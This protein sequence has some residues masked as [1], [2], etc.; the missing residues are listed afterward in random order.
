LANTIVSL[1]KKDPAQGVA[2][3]KGVSAIFGN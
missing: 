3:L 2:A 1:F